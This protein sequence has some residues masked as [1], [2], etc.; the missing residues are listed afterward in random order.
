MICFFSYLNV[1]GMITFLLLLSF[2]NYKAFFIIHLKKN[3]AGFAIILAR[4]KVLVYLSLFR[5]FSSVCISNNSNIVHVEACCMFSGC[6]T[7]KD[8]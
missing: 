8:G 6:F 1:V 4:N 3:I 2:H 7:L 5:T